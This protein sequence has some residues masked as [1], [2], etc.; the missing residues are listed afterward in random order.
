MHA[1]YPMSEALWLEWIQDAKKESDTAEGKKKLF[2]LYDLAQEDYV[3]IAIWKDYTEYILE[4]FYKDFTDNITTLDES[5]EDWIDHTRQD[6]L[7]AVRAS[8]NHVK[9]SQEIWKLYS[10]FELAILGRFNEDEYQLSRTKKMYLDR[11]AVLHIDCED[12][13]NSYSQFVTQYSN[14]NYE[15]SMLEA[16]KIYAKTKAAAEERDYYELQLTS[17]GY[18][19]D[20]FYQYIE[21]ELTTKNMFALNHV[22][23]LYE[24]AIIYYCTD[25]SLWDD[26]ILFLVNLL[27]NSFV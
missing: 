12:T 1:I 22:R 13:F 14:T 5:V 26:Y 15:E 6:L 23:S 21:Y 4:N 25:P 9:Q 18:A 3:S 24:R 7:K 19:L 8:S 17:T 11:L 10:E 16:N 27:Y 20:T 2:Q